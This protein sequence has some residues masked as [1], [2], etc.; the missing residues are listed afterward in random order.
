MSEVQL[1]QASLEYLGY[2]NLLIQVYCLLRTEPVFLYCTHV[3]QVP[4]F[5]NAVPG[6][7]QHMPE[8][9]SY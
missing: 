8:H 7:M 3:G 5:A 4:G 9:D 1:T 6:A 2:R